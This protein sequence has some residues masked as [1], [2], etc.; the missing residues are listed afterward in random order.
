MQIAYGQFVEDAY[1]NKYG[2]EH[3]LKAIFLQILLVVFSF[4]PANRAQTSQ[5]NVQ[6]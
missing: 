5:Q 1:L 3:R 6:L 4:C 2:Y